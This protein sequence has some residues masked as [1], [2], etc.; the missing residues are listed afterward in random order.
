MKK[1]TVAAV[2]GVV[3][4]LALAAE[5]ARLAEFFQKEPT[6]PTMAIP[7]ESKQLEEDLPERHSVTEKWVL[8]P[9]HETAVLLDIRSAELPAAKALSGL[10]KLYPRKEDIIGVRMLDCGSKM[11][12]VFA[13]TQLQEHALLYGFQMNVRHVLY[14]TKALDNQ[15][16][17][18]L[19]IIEGLTIDHV[20]STKQKLESSWKAFFS[21]TLDT[22]D[23]EKRKNNDP[24]DPWPP[25]LH[26]V[27]FHQSTA[28]F[29]S[30]KVTV[31]FR[32]SVYL[33]RGPIKL[34]AFNAFFNCRTHQLSS[35]CHH[36]MR[37]DHHEHN[38]CPHV[39]REAC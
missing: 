33:S 25:K 11:V 29:Y 20:D 27:Y 38:R 13:N 15:F 32:G 28:G 7:Y 26:D 34:E 39:R 19:L 14:A 5:V 21:K 16:K 18:T 10:R 31:I 35:Y 8:S 24:N 36:C 22:R 9:E 37:V 12:I 3:N 4:G 30:G 17:H 2:A 1:S 23:G 6:S